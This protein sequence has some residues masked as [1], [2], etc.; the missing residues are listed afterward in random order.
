M[1]RF[2]SLDDALKDLCDVEQISGQKDFL[3]EQWLPKPVDEVFPFFSDAENLATITPEFLDFKILSKSTPK[4]QAGTLLN[5]QLKLH[6]IPIH[7]T[8]R[9]D[10]WEPG[11]Y[12]T[13]TQLK[14][15]YKK[16]HHTHRFYPMKGG[17]LMTDRVLYQ[18]PLGILGGIAA[19]WKVHGDVAEIF[20]YRRKVIS[21]R[22]GKLEYR[23]EASAS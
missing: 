8:T 10:D 15:P 7:W 12:F 17:T 14:G 16:W 4:N 13:D 22:F 20:R 18:L 23:R 3:A 5:Y 9:I 2:R 21:E 11:K 6:G 1:F 19:G